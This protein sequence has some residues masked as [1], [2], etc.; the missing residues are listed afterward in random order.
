LANKAVEF[1]IRG[2][3]DWCKLLGPARPYTGDP[4]STRD[5]AG[6]SR[7]IPD[8][9]SRALLKKHG[10]EDKLK[11]DKRSVRTARRLRT[12]VVMTSSV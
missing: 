9:K 5:R 4:R 2:A 6:L 10:L 8:E 3:I 7:L 1:T 12:H 11:K